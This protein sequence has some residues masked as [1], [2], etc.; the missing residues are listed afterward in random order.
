VP[1]T[2]E[3][4]AD[5]DALLAAIAGMRLPVLLKAAAGGGGKGMRVVAERD[6]AREHIAAAM[7]EGQSSFGRPDLIVEEFLPRARH[8]EV[9]ILGDGR[10]GV[11]HLFD[12]ECSLQRRS[13]KV[14]EEAPV[15]SLSGELRDEILGHAV[16]LGAAV[17]YAGLGTVEFIVHAGRAFFLEVNPRIQV[18]HTVTEEITGLDLVELQ[19]R[20]IGEGRLPRQR[21]IRVTGCAVQ[22][23]LYAEDVAKG[24]L[25]STGEIERLAFPANVRVDA[26]V[27]AG[28]RVTPFYDPM[29]AKLIV[30]G[31]DRHSAYAALRKA[32][33]ETAVLGV[34]TNRDFLA[35]LAAREDVLGNQ[36]HTSSIDAMLSA[37]GTVEPEIPREQAA[38]AA[39]LWLRKNRGPEADPWSGWTGLTGWRLRGGEPTIAEAPA[40]RLSCGGGTFEASYGERAGSGVLTLRIGDEP[41][42]AF[43]GE[44]DG[45]DVHVI[46]GRAF[47]MESSVSKDAVSFVA[48]DGR[49]YRFRIEPYLS[50]AVFAG[51]GGGDGRVRAPLV[52]R[53][54]VVDVAVGAAVTG[55][56]RLA[57]LESMKMELSIQAPWAGV[58][59]LVNCSADASVERDQVLFHIARAGEHAA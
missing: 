6:G 41:F 2:S 46:N 8:V 7:R 47:V 36:I 19:L 33:A 37:E 55:G 1:G 15:E 5:V 52:G 26:G 40:I 29:I 51:E 35:G 39:A 48:P 49:S 20:A 24:F 16:R 38:L 31:A 44:P 21:D 57:V 10:G 12:R 17:D 4:S 58:V 43:A 54:A 23:R 45:R 3:P 13:Q 50:G 42:A 18:E 22:A 59:S 30:R 14:I 53:V 32:L 27:A 9:Q 34:E 28:E 25:P 56:Q 11:V